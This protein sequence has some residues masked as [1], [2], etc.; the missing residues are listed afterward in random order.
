[1]IKK[2]V[3]IACVGMSPTFYA[4]DWQRP[5]RLNFPRNAYA[6]WIMY[7][8]FALK[9]RTGPQRVLS[10]TNIPTLETISDFTPAIGAALAVSG[11]SNYLI[12]KIPFLELPTKRKIARSL[13]RALLWNFGAATAGLLV[14]P[15]DQ[16]GIIIKEQYTDHQGNIMQCTIPTPCGPEREWQVTVND[17][18]KLYD[19]NGLPLVSPFTTT[20]V[21]V[22]AYMIADCALQSQTISTLSKKINKHVEV[23]QG[24]GTELL[25]GAALCAARY[26]VL[27][28]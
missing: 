2:L 8:E 22:G 5:S 7:S 17:Y 24:T 1:M 16:R 14:T 13:K 10:N 3:L 18:G 26:F 12:N 9:D 11:G 4:M 19:I 25:K 23:E 21:G 28:D 27:R 15:V 6:H 20:L